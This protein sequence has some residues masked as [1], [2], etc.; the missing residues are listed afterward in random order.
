[1]RNKIFVLGYDTKHSIDRTIFLAEKNYSITFVLSHYFP[2]VENINKYKNVDLRF[3]DKEILVHKKTRFNTIRKII[4]DVSPSI[5][6]VHYCSFVNFHASLLSGVKP[7]IGILMGA[8]VDISNT[9]VPLHVRLEIF[10]T[11]LFLP[12]LELLVTKTERIKKICEN[13]NI[14]GDILTIPW[15]ININNFKKNNSI[16]DKL[17]VRKKLSLPSSAWLILSCRAVVRE[18]NIIDIVKGFYLFLNQNSNSKLVIINY[19][20]DPD[21]LAEIKD[22]I[23]ELNLTND[24]LFLSSLSS[25]KLASMY[26][27]CDL[28]ICNRSFDGFPQTF[29]EAGIT[30]LP[31]LSSK[32]EAY[33]DILEDGKDVIYH[34]G[35][36]ENISFELSRIYENKKL[37]IQLSKNIIKTVQI[38]GDIEKWSKVFIDRLEHLLKTKKVIHIP[39]YK[40]LMGAFILFFIFIS[41]K[42]IFKKIKLKL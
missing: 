18:S 28:L 6:I 9:K 22:T 24:I 2:Y 42:N 1:M 16:S 33:A 35:K 26:L 31:I 15:G 3:L 11:K 39:F 21:Y 23:N 34:N 36:P 32:L 8:E 40:K 4:K 13:N 20:H 38:Y 30:G 27:A 5:I 19:Y 12:Y 37:Q 41:R 17:K 25:D 14:K 29:F 7:I 10:F